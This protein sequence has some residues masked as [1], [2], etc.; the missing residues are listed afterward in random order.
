MWVGLSEI[1]GLASLRWQELVVGCG[2]AGVGAALW[3]R[4][5]AKKAEGQR[6]R[7]ETEEFEAYAGFE[8]RLP[9]DGAVQDLGRRVCKL[10]SE[11]SR[12]YRVAMLVRDA[13]GQP[14]VADSVGMDDLSVR[15]LN[16]WGVEVVEAERQGGVGSRR[17]DGGLGMRVAGNSFAVV[18]GK[19]SEEIGCGRAVVIPLRTTAG[20]VVG[21]L[22]MGADSMLSVRR[23]ML[24][25][26]LLPLEAL[27]VKLGRTMENA[28]LA[29]RLLR[30]EKLAGLG[31][32][33]GGMAHALSNPLTAVLGFAE[34]IA[35]TSDE[36]RVKTDAG[37]IVREALRMRET[38]DA[39]LGFWRPPSRLDEPVDVTELMRE[40]AAACREKLVNR[41]V[42][43]I[44]QAGDDVPMVRGSRD[45]LRQMLEHLLNNAAQAVASAGASQGGEGHAIRLTV[46]QEDRSVHLVV[47]D[48]GPGFR[49]PGRAFDPFH[50]TRQP[51]QG[52]GLGLSIC[53]GIVREH[54]GEISAYNVLP[55][56]AAV[57]VELPVGEIAAEKNGSAVEKGLFV[58][59]D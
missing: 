22:V 54:G 9:Q 27:A 37:M 4:T 17:G 16:A 2:F 46:S 49:E 7:R 38:V 24:Q 45:R 5:Q 14:Y 30:A 57:V 25:E 32:L 53:Q 55:H 13:G 58:V 11:K 43:M 35:H 1:R 10:V 59:S 31:L 40:L 39:L 12:F 51:G 6:R 44:V 28:A 8:I 3:C 19:S 52:I 34:L 36:S 23:S 50:T 33:A 15:A 26:A 48:T 18:L 47:S 21:A 29:E 56:G 42:R 41:G 20:R